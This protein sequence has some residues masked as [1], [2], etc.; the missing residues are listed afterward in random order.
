MTYG[1]QVSPD[2]SDVAEM[3]ILL[4]R[5][6]ITQARQE[7]RMCSR[8]I[9]DE[10]KFLRRRNTGEKSEQKFFTKFG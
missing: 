9:W 7:I 4:N 8:A 6:S 2:R 1:L 5:G 3:D 10:V